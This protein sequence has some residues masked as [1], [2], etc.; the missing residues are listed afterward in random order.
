MID[1]FKQA[2]I[3]YFTAPSGPNSIND[4]DDAAESAKH[5][6]PHLLALLNQYDGFLVACYSQ[7]PLVPWLK[8]QDIV[9][10]QGKWVTGIFE[11]SVAT[12]LQLIK[13]SQRFGIVSTGKVWEEILS[14]AAAALLGTDSKASKKFAGVE[15]TGLNATELHDAPAEEVRSKMMEATKRLLRKGN[16]GAV[17]LGCAGMSGMNEM[18]RQA[19]VEELGEQAGKQVRIVDGVQ[20]GVA[21]LEG[22]TRTDF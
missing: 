16:V 9:A 3:D 7:H 2:T 11:A 12:S 15:T 4:E 5:C 13:P 22:A 21:W 20:A 1:V 14:D 19:A 8:E 6:A 17:C 10:T 18:V